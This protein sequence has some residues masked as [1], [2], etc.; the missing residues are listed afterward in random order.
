MDRFIEMPVSGGRSAHVNIARINSHA[1]T[2]LA[3]QKMQM[4]EVDGEALCVPL[5]QSTINLGCWRDCGDGIRSR[6]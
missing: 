1:A 4:V 3:D 6:G 2:S 5:R